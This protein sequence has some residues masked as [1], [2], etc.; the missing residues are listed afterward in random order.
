[1][2]EPTTGDTATCKSCNKL[3]VY[4]GQHWRHAGQMQPRHPATPA[5]P[6]AAT[7]K[8]PPSYTFTAAG[9]EYTA[10][11][12]DRYTVWG[13]ARLYGEPVGWV[14]VAIGYAYA[15]GELTDEDVRALA[16]PEPPAG[17]VRLTEKYPE[18]AGK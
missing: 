13:L 9:D 7:P 10:L 11:P 14:P 16:R 1:M 15:R 6:A 17:L 5:A 18:A 12:S 3:I 4:T 8:Q 2:E